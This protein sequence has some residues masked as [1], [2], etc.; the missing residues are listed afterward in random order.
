MQVPDPVTIERDAPRQ[1]SLDGSVGE[2]PNAD[3]VFVVW[4]GDRS[5]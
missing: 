4:A 5:S 2:I 3:A 1:E